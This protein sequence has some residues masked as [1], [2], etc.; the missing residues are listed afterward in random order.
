LP[1]MGMA[2]T[3]TARNGSAEPRRADSILTSH[4]RTLLNQNAQ[5]E[6]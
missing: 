5:V 4:R 1:G 2:T 6:R 3:P